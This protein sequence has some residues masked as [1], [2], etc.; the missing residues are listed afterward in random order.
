MPQVCK[1]CRSESRDEIDALLIAGREP[2]R[3]IAVR[4]G[5]SPTSLL[6]HR[7]HIPKALAVVASAREEARAETLLDQI[8]AAKEHA[9]RLVRRA[10]E[11]GD[12][13]GAVAGLRVLL[14]AL[15]LVGKVAAEGPKLSRSP[16]WL[17]L[18]ER[19]A[20]ALE[21]FPEALE[22]V[23]AV[24]GELDRGELRPAPIRVTLRL[25]PAAPPFEPEAGA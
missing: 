19:L 5:T 12:V 18:M 6:R 1:A 11:D 14:D 21:P 2:L 25:P 23:R 4:F 16:E 22:A 15:E 10:E 8:H 9:V 24:C 13:R 3:N 17:A 7:E 20:D